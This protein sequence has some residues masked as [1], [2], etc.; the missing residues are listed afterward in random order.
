MR[1]SNVPGLLR[2]FPDEGTLIPHIP[3]AQAPGH[4]DRYAQG[5]M[6]KKVLGAQEAIQGGVGKVIMASGCIEAPISNA[7]AGNGTVLTA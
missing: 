1:H 5:R 2:E 4:L 6:K 7:L 3:L